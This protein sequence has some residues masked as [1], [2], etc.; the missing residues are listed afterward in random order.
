[1]DNRELWLAAT[2]VELADSRDADFDETTYS[3]RL[4]LHLAQ[5]LAPAEVGVLIG[6]AS[7]LKAAAASTERARRLVSFEASHG[8]GPDT[9]CYS[10]GQ[11][12]LNESLTM[13]DGR[14]PRFAAAAR[15][16]GFGIV[17]SLPIRR[18]HE[19]VGVIS[20]ARTGEHPLDATETSL[21]QILA[22]AA[23]IAVLQQRA[24][25]RSTQTAAQLRHALDSRVLIEQAKGARRRT[26]RHHA[27]GGVRAAARLRSPAQ[28]LAH[29]GG[30]Q[31]DQRGTA[32]ARTSSRA[33]N[34]PRS[35]AG[36][37][38]GLSS[39]KTPPSAEPLPRC[40]PHCR[41]SAASR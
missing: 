30:G 31:N 36:T 14:W 20:V 25:R 22:E 12:V 18:H 10:S 35:A 33:R 37:V 19:T 39:G 16:A 9:A 13:A 40:L 24:L 32:G 11:P 21:A 2:L 17:S 6:D 1:M 28:P 3:G 41:L 7:A 27:G 38:A 34:R 26:A 29:R 5:L 8:E 4:A 23:A 15:A